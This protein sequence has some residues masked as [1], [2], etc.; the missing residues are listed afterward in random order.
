MTIRASPNP[1]RVRVAEERLDD[2]RARLARTR[3]PDEAPGAGWA[4]GAELEFVHGLV[5]HWRLGFD[6]PAQEA[7]LNSLD[8]FLV[9]LDELDLH[10]VHAPGR[11]PNPLP[12]LL[13][14][15][16]PGS[17][18]DFHEVVPRLADPERYD[19]DSVHAANVVAVSLPGFTFSYAPGQRRLDL[20][21]MADVCARLMIDVL[22]YPRFV[23]HGG[24]LGAYVAAR[25]AFDHPEAVLGVHLGL[26]PLRPELRWSDDSPEHR[27]Y[28]QE[29]RRWE[30]EESGYS[31]IQGTKPQTLAFALTDSPA[32]LAAWIVEKLHTWTD[33]DGDLEQ[34]LGLDTVLTNLTLYWVTGAIN[35]SFWLY[36]AIRHGPWP[37]PDFLA[38][39][40]GYASFPRDARHPPRSVAE[41]AFAIQHWTEMPRGGH[42]AA[43]EVPEL[44]AADIAAFCRTLGSRSPSNSADS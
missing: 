16:W 44:L 4:H 9:R 20:A 34:A 10:F 15:G 30:R 38:T 36:Y 19:G 12:L 31:T 41:R 11:A 24:D 18:F 26:L 32:G 27:V 33:N 39:P 23:V 21:E 22:G 42:F 6:W 14:H 2:L 25:L 37:L 3:W 1:F 43:L 5:E 28:D 8:Q 17:F 13:I 35:S 40:T 7:K 29:L